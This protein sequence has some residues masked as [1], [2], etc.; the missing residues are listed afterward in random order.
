MTKIGVNEPCPCSSGKKYKKCCQSK[1]Q[2]ERRKKLDEINKL[3]KIYLNGQEEH[4]AK[5][6]FCINHYKDLFPNCKIINLTNYINNDNYRQILTLNY[7]KSTIILVEKSDLTN[8]LFSEKSNL[9]SN[10][11][12]LIYKGAYKTFEA[13]DILKYYKD[14]QSMITNRDNG[15]TM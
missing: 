11:I 8:L 7:N 2:E 14:I 15:L 6:T 12:I 10:D 3:E 13:I 4:S 9:E 5:M 1:D